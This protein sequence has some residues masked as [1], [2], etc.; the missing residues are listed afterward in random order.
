M[1]QDG[2]GADLSN[3]VWVSCEEGGGIT[4]RGRPDSVVMV[5]SA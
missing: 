4:Y 2:G 5:S 1:I 3:L